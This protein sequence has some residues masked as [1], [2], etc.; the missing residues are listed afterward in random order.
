MA[1]Q[2]ANSGGGR[3]Q[4]SAVRS[5][6]S[7]VRGAADRN[8]SVRVFGSNLILDDCRSRKQAAGVPGLLQRLSNA[9]LTGR[10]N[11]QSVHEGTTTG[12]ESELL[13]IAT[14]LSQPP[15]NA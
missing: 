10:Q 9:S 4:D 7:S 12:R 1:S 13:S 14:Y 2:S 11:T 3:I 6:V 5:P 8:D 15:S